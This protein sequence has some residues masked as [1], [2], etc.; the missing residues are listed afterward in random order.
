MASLSTAPIE[1]NSKE[2]RETH[3]TC[4]GSFSE[5]DAKPSSQ[6]DTRCAHNWEKKGR[7]DFS[8]SDGCCGDFSHKEGFQSNDWV[9][10]ASL[11]ASRVFPSLGYVLDKKKSLRN[12]LDRYERL[13]REV[14]R[15]LDQLSKVKGEVFVRAAKEYAAYVTLMLKDLSKTSY[16]DL[17]RIVKECLLVGDVKREIVNGY[18]QNG[19]ISPM[20]FEVCL[21]GKHC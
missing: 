9:K 15:K 6:D 17:Q 18:F 19:D 10:G 4:D 16:G 1:K 2:N 13:P 5:K 14:E 8:F 3:S 7:G 21:L 12:Y 11:S 20:V